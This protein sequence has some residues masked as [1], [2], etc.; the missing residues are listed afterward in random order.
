MRFTDLFPSPQPLIACLH[1]LP[2]PGSPQYG[3][4]MRAV[5]DTALAEVE[6]LARYPVAGFIVENFRDIPFYPQ[7][8]PAETVAALATVTREIV[9]LTRLP[10]GVNALRND[11][12]AAMAVATAAEAQFIR[13]NVHMGAVVSDQGVLQGASHETLRLRAALR[14]SVLVFADVGVKHATPLTPRSLAT[15]TRDVSERGLAD[16][17]IVSGESTGAATSLD[18][19][20]TVRQHTH[21]PVLVGS[22][23]TPETLP[24]LYAN[25]DGFI[26]GSYLKQHGRA[27]NA[28]E[29]AR[30]AT[31]VAAWQALQARSG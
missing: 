19:I 23:T 8:L 31:L 25:V 13:V 9:R 18:D 29:E 15:E 2:L 4:T 22:G 10:V 5:Y 12:P 27:E 20:A 3:G 26:V 16:A 24:Q 14:S 28:L 6:I 1:L 21:L 17:V 7:R 30:V 11:A